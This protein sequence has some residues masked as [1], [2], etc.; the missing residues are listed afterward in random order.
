[1]GVT[2]PRVLPRCSAVR[3][4]SAL[5]LSPRRQPTRP[6]TRRS[7]GTKETKRA[8]KSKRLPA[9]S[10]L[11]RA[12]RPAAARAR[13]PAVR[14][15][16]ADEKYATG[17]DLKK[18]RGG[19]VLLFHLR[20]KNAFRYARPRTPFGT[21]DAGQTQLHIQRTTSIRSHRGAAEYR[22]S[23]RTHEIQATPSRW[24]G[25]PHR[26]PSAPPPP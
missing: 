23:G 2:V 12:A 7:P 5:R 6:P 19:V 9:I 4:I 25:R 11:T 13:L 3:R 21:C 22:A 15:A 20:K 16:L 18:W 14:S 10:E 8:P 17:G 24:R 1:M 26:M